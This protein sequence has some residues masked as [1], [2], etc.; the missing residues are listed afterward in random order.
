MSRIFK[1]FALA[2]SM[3]TT[4]PFFKVHDFYKGINGYAVMFYPLVGALLGFILYGVALVLEPYMPHFHLGVILFALWVVLTGA[5]HLDGFAD[6]VDGLFV[7]KERS[8][9]VM[10]DP[11]NGGMGMLF[12]GTFLLL[13]ASSVAAL[14][15][16][17]LLPLVLLLP[18]LMIVL[19]I[20]FYPYVSSGMSMLA[21]EEF[22]SKQLV[23]AL[24][25]SLLFVFLYNAWFL[26]VGALFIMLLSKRFFMRR[27]G[28]F[29]GDIYGFT[30]EVTELFLLNLIIAG[31]A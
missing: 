21:K 28:G 30:I 14:P 7:A 11:H 4:I 29:T 27:Y 24:L 12:G 18:R 17:E 23:T 13:K 25:Y 20:Y 22:Q 5:L 3:L 15:S 26:L 2:L 31:L 19:S 8:L 1:G 10:K 6:T 16:Y 9:E